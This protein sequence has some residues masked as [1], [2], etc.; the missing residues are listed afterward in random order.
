M[1][2]MRA[3]LHGGGSRSPE[4]A[5]PGLLEAICNKIGKNN[6]RLSEVQELLANGF[7]RI[8]GPVPPQPASEAISGMS[9]D[10]AVSLIQ[11]RLQAQSVLL[12]SLE[13]ESNRLS[14]LG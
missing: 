5:E 6:A 7:D 2:D 8:M 1:S 10:S 12:Q 9:E 14:K 4:V 3:Q 11:S 13:E